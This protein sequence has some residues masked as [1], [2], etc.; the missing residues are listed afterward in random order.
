MKQQMYSRINV[1]EIDITLP[2]R[3]ELSLAATTPYRLQLCTVFGAA[4][5]KYCGHYYNSCI[6]YRIAGVVTTLWTE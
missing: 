2:G 4:A 3:S 6:R 1:F 5:S